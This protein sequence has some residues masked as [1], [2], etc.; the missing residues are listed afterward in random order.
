MLILN[1]RRYAA[2][3]DFAPV[4][5]YPLGAK[6][7]GTAL[8][9]L[10]FVALAAGHG[11]PGVRVTQAGQLADALRMALQADAPSLVEIEVA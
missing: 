4:F 2:L 7:E 5:G 11:L 3:Q 6:V 9:D 8:P 1:N 10:D